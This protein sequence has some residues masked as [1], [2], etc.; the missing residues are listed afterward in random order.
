MKI[1]IIGRNY[2]VSDRLKG[3]IE[4]KVGKFEKFF[5]KDVAVKVV[6][7]ESGNARYKMELNLTS[8]SMF[9]RGEVESDNMYQNLD[10]CI[11]KVE[12]QVIKHSD[13]FMNKRAINK[14][15]FEVF[16]YFEEGSNNFE[17]LKITKRKKFA[18]E[19]MTEDEALDQM[20]LVGNDFFIF[21]NLKSNAVCV[22]YKKAD[23]SVGLIETK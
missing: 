16:D 1:D 23:G 9:V 13:K 22:L 3:L 18:L 4:K 15:D 12:K 8:G 20:D 5:E 14:A 6:C 11:A 10:T 2:K 7:T 21:M 17:K 19:A